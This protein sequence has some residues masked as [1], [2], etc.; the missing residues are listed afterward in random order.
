MANHFWVGSGNWSDNTNHWAATTGGAPGSTVPTTGDKCFFDANSG[1]CTL[2]QNVNIGSSDIDFTA[3]T[4]TFTGNGKTIVCFNILS[5][6]VNVR[7]I[8]LTNC[9]VTLTGQWQVSGS[10]VTLTTT[11]STIST[12]YHDA[13]GTVAAFVGGGLTYNI[14]KLNA[15]SQIQ[16]VTG[17]N[18]FSIL[19]CSGNGKTVRFADSST[20]TVSACLAHG[21]SGSLIT[22][23]T[24]TGGTFATLSKAKGSVACNYLSLKDIHVGGGAGWYAGVNTTDVSGNSGW[25]FTHSPYNMF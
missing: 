3:Y 23:D 4:G 8:D 9:T 16:R 22:F 15:T 14:V 2:D 7:T 25:L 13:A 5:T 10:G 17:N 12:S 24:V 19:D 1:N 18:T 20:Q 6:G 21:A 11:G